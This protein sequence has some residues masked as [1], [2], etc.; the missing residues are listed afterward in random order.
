MFMVV[1]L[2]RVYDLPLWYKWGQY[3]P[4]F[5]KSQSVQ[6][7]ASECHF[8]GLGT[9]QTKCPGYDMTSGRYM[10]VMSNMVTTSMATWMVRCSPGPVPIA[11]ALKLIN[12]ITYCNLVTWLQAITVPTYHDIVLCHGTVMKLKDRHF[13][14]NMT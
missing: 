4:C 8:N 9:G 5:L 2:P 14:V 6:S 7:P 3:L 1:P 11:Q 12:V 13:Y 10:T